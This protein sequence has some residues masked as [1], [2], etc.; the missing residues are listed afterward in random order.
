MKSGGGVVTPLTALDA[1]A[2]CANANIIHDGTA[3]NNRKRQMNK[4]QI[5]QEKPNEVEV[6]DIDCDLPIELYRILKF[7]LPYRIYGAAFTVGEDINEMEVS[8]ILGA[9]N[10]ALV[11]GAEN[12][13][14]VLE[15]KKRLD[16]AESEE[17]FDCDYSDLIGI[18]Q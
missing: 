14:W 6:T 2:T 9:I 3:F 12:K 1:N 11:W 8:F 10:D 13:E 16:A 15:V 18:I 5:P 7:S 17:E 4:P